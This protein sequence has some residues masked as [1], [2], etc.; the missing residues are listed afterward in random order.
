ME[1]MMRHQILS[2]KQ[3]L[4]KAIELLRSVGV[5]EPEIRIGQYPHQLS[6]GTK[7]RIAIARAL[8][9]EPSLILAD[10]PTTA[11]DV[12]IQAQILDLLR[13]LKEHLNVAMILITNNMGIA[14]DICEREKV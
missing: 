11:L 4:V 7:Q 14:A 12:T 10:K 3:A 9:C 1:V 8:S 6:G 5:P 13:A 2:K